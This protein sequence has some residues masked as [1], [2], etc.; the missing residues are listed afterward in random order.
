M[1]MS[2]TMIGRLVLGCMAVFLIGCNLAFLTAVGGNLVTWFRLK[3]ASSLL[4]LTYVTLSAFLG[5]PAGWRLALGVVAV[6]ADTLALFH[7]WASINHAAK[8]GITGLVPLF[9]TPT[10]R[11]RELH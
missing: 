9:R 11:H 10:T 6:C 5:N 4:L 2:F 1:L 8:N 3:A 7:M